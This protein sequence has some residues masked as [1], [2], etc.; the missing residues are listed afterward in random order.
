MAIDNDVTST[1]R[2]L[3]LLSPSIRKVNILSHFVVTKY[4]DRIIRMGILLK[5][6]NFKKNSIAK[7]FSRAKPG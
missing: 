4:Y 6:M 3:T 2:S 1:N 5:Y 7:M